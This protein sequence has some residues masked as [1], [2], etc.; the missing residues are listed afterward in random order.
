MTSSDDRACRSVSTY[1]SNRCT[2]CRT[3]SLIVVLLL[4]FILR[5]LL[6]WWLLLSWCCRW[7]CLR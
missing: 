5:L 6:G 1:C 7:R 2:G 3:L 4:I